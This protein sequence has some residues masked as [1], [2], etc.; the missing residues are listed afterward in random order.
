VSGGGSRHAKRDRERAR[1]ERVARKQARRQARS[2]VGDS[3]ES[4]SDDPVVDERASL[5]QSEVLSR[6]AELHQQ[7]DDGE[8]DFDAFEASKAELIDQLDV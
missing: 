3:P 8:I 2:D 5:P 6:L 4:V 7:F 1:R